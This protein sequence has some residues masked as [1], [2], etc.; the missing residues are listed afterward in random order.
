[1]FVKLSV[2]GLAAAGLLTGLGIAHRAPRPGIS[3]DYVE[4]RSCD[5]YTGP[6]FAN[7]EMT[8]GGHEGIMA[9]AIRNGSFD[10][11]DL[12]GLNVI[13]VVQAQGTLGDVDRYP[14]P[15]RSV[16]IVDEAAS[17]AQRDALL[18]FVQEK[19]GGL[20]GQTV[21]IARAPMSVKLPSTCSSGGCANVRAG[22]L[23]E[24]E[25]RCLGGKDHVCGNEEL[26]YPPL[27]NVENARPAFTLAGVFRGPGLGTQFDE[28]NRR[29][30]Y[31]AT[32]GE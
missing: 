19:A 31:L 6:C 7:A 3:G 21:Q 4:V 25:T 14:Q 10:G 23:V 20:L 17:S 2:V 26:F 32:F 13:A 9:W 15:T 27:T 11:V 30:A 24:I 22:E 8:I 29:S 28:A 18:H 1:M 5:V 16:L 12:T